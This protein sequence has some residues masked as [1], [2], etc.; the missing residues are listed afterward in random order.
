M[1]YEEGNTYLKM[2]SDQFTTPPH[3]LKRLFTGLPVNHK[4][5]KKKKKEPA[6]TE[7]LHIGAKFYNCSQC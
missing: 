4:K 5:K 1:V 2:F 6:G 7:N 3:L